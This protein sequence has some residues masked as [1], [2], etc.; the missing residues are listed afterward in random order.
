MAWPWRAAM[1]KSVLVLLVMP[2]GVTM[3]AEQDDPH[4]MSLKELRAELKSMGATCKACTEKAD[5]ADRLRE[6]RASPPSATPRIGS[7]AA[8][9]AAKKNCK[10]GCDLCAASSS[11][12]KTVCRAISFCEWKEPKKETK[13]ESK[14]E[15]KKEPKKD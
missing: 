15:P 9:C 1:L 12:S 3:S 11:Q 2:L 10:Q 8:K 14:K 6:A 4:S 7:F 5:F 13:K